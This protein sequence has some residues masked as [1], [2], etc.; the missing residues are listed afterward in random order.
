M[1]VI[2]DKN[3]FDEKLRNHIAIAEK[4]TANNT[5]LKLI[6]A[7]NYGGRWDI[8]QSMRQIAVEIEAGKLSSQDISPELIQSKLALADLP[9]PDLFIRTGGEL[10]ISNF[11]LWQQAYTE[12]YFSPVLWPDFDLAEFDKALAFFASRER[13]FGGIIEKTAG[14]ES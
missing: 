7:A 11:L 4:L 13:R 8:T 5:G 2:G 12:L 10:R 9:E 3:R 14:A 6:I 1:R